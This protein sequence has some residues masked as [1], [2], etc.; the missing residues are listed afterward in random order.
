[1][2]LN[3]PTNLWLGAFTA[4]WSVIVLVL[5][6]QGIEISL[7]LATGVTAAAGALVLLVANQTPTV[8]AGSD[9]KVQTPTGQ[10]N[11]TATVDIAPSG[12]VTV[13]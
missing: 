13:S 3:R 10:P 4:I 7:E 2:I 1:M 9:I 8:A 12:E 6:S 5:K 11:A